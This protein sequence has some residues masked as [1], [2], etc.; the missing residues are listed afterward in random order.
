MSHPIKEQIRCFLCRKHNPCDEPHKSIDDSQC[1][2][3][4][5]NVKYVLFHL[6]RVGKFRLDIQ[7]DEWLCQPCYIQIVE[8]DTSLVHLMHKQRNL[9]KLVD[10][11][12][13]SF[14]SDIDAECLEE[15]AHMEELN[16]EIFCEEANVS[17]R[18]IAGTIFEAMGGKIF[19]KDRRVFMAQENSVMSIQSEDDCDMIEYVKED[20]QCALCV[21]R[22]RNRNQLQKHVKNVHKKISCTMCSF[23]HRNEDYVMLHMNLHEGRSENQCRF[24]NKVFTAKSSTI[25]HMEAHM[26]TK[27]Y[28]C[29]KCGLCFSQMTMLYTHKLQ[30]EAEENPLRCEICKQIF[31]TIRTYR[32]HMVTHR[33]DRPRHTCEYCGKTFTERY[34]LKVHKRAHTESVEHTVAESSEG[35]HYAVDNPQEQHQLDQQQQPSTMQANTVAA[36]NYHKFICIICDQQFTNKE[37]LDKHMEKRHDVILKSIKTV[38]IKD[39]KSRQIKVWNKVKNMDLD[40][41]TE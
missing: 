14:E 12:A 22:F 27:K 33:A 37:L 7:S 29:D 28:Q 11:A 41:P 36:T 31:K 26:D 5:K 24:C 18:E 10:N 16:D 25:R 30:H 13:I 19:H 8:Y 23:A 4:K 35:N 6:A 21:M 2:A 40:A 9:V 1:P 32:H 39:N 20:I 15:F 34:T 17:D 3:S 38:S